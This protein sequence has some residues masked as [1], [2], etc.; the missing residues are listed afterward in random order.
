M[1]WK[2]LGNQQL[3]LIQGKGLT[4]TPEI[5]KDLLVPTTSPLAGLPVMVYSVNDNK[6][7]HVRVS[8]Q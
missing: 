5:Y 3:V 2:T 7:C 8:S 6:I 4:V 1:T